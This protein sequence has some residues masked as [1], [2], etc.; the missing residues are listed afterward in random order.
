LLT[1]ADANDQKVKEIAGLLLVA[2][3]LAENAARVDESS[4][5]KSTIELPNTAFIR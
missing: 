1:V 4:I 5:R 3:S 2:S